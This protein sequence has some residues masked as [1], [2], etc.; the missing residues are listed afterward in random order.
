MGA[1]AFSHLAHAA[2]LSS[3]EQAARNY[4]NGGA[5]LFKEVNCTGSSVS[6]LNATETINGLRLIIRNTDASNNVTLCPA[7]A[8]T[9]GASGLQL[10]ATNATLFVPPL[11]IGSIRNQT[12]TCFSGGGNPIVEVWMEKME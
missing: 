7:A 6:I 11:T 9:G 2:S 5:T 4:T 10:T 1:A 8:C 3:A 12:F